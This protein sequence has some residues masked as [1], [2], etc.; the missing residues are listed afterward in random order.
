MVN[1]K[2]II[3]DPHAVCVNP[4]YERND[5][6]GPAFKD[7]HVMCV[8]QDDCNPDAVCEN[9]IVVTGGSGS[10]KSTFAE[11]LLV[12]RQKK[13]GG[14]LI[15][16]ATMHRSDDPET[17]QRITRHRAMRSG[18]GFLTIEA[19]RNITKVLK[20]S[21]EMSWSVPK[22]R[23]DQGNP[24]ADDKCSR[25]LPGDHILLED[26]GNLLANEMFSP[27]GGETPAR[28][29]EDILMIAAANAGWASRATAQTAG[30]D[31]ISKMIM[32]A[33]GAARISK[34]IAP[35]AGTGGISETMSPEEKAARRK[36]T[37]IVVTNEVGCDGTEYSKETERYIL[38]LNQINRE[39]VRHAAYAVRIVCGLPLVLRD[40]T[41]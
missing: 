35:A 3:T 16:L 2:D 20:I 25:I 17:L 19:E 18:R 21:D 10:G 31:G 14:R 5:G 23:Y 1:D 24:Q 9:L 4:A 32:P 29:A 6:I 37:L 33:A 39:L 8:N 13:S 30:S 27:E 36:G 34:T 12:R 41:R 7:S 38:A 26:L 11:N 40:I 15:Y 22:S 28:I